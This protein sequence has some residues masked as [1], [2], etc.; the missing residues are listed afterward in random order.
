VKIWKLKSAGFL[1]HSLCYYYSLVLYLNA[2]YLHTIGPNHI[3]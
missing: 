3:T 1:G 2:K